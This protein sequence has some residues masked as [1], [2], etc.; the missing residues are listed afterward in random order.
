[1]RIILKPHT[2]PIEAAARIVWMKELTVSGLFQ[3][4][5]EFRGLDDVQRARIDAFIE[6]ERELAR[7]PKDPLYL[8]RAW[9]TI[10]FE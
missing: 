1:M 7:K 4:G 3:F 6:E 2:D 9:T 8:G 5:F 10:K